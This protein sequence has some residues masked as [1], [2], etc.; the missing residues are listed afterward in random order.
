MGET[1]SEYR[2]KSPPTDPISTV[3][4]VPKSS[5][6]LLVSSWDSYVRVYDVD[7]NVMRK[8]IFHDGEAV[9]DLTIAVMINLLSHLFALH[10]LVHY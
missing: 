8:K 9:L 7:N 1:R 2:L 6:I 4:F 5:T 3:Q 10:P